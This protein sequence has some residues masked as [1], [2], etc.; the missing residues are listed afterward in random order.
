[1]ILDYL[2]KVSDAQ[3]VTASAA[4]TSYIDTKAAGDAYEGAFA[5]FKI[6]TTMASASTGSTV[7]FIIQTSETTSFASTTT[8]FDSGAI[9]EATLVAGYEILAG[10]L[11]QG[12]KRYIRAY[13]TVA[14]QDLNAG[15]VTAVIVKDIATSIQ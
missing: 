12:A 6:D 10:R 14:N 8:L 9:A 13:Y 4:S 7:N 11:A 2:T 1:M 15:A 5:Y 3:A